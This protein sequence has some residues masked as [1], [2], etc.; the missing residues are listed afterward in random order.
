M[1]D[2]KLQKDYYY[3]VHSRT[4]KRLPN[5]SELKPVSMEQ[6]EDILE[7]HNI[8]NKEIAKTLTYLDNN[9]I[10]E[11]EEPQFLLD[12]NYLDDQSVSKELGKD[13]DLIR[14]IMIGLGAA[15]LLVLIGSLILFK[16]KVQ[17]KLP[18]MGK[19]K[20]SLTKSVLNKK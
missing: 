5:E 14:K 16:D 20:T 7:E 17:I 1:V 8:S 12:Q 3:D 18:G 19:K 2:P 4:L 11:E 13:S 6:V 10:L 15:I 9:N